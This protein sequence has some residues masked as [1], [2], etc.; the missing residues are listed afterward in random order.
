VGGR[1]GRIAVR[2]RCVVRESD[3]QTQR[4]NA[5]S[6]YSL[7]FELLC[8]VV[9]FVLVGVWID[10]HY[11]SGPW[12][13]LIC[14]FL[15]LIGGFYNLYRGVSRLADGSGP[16]RSRAVPRAS[17]GESEAPRAPAAIRTGDELRRALDPQ[18]DSEAGSGIGRADSPGSNGAME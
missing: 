14:L 11:S 1:R 2:A 15:G 3:K 12:G 7:G 9:G 13:T 17:G 5:A 10:R 16:G 4:G 6:A 18:P 8:A